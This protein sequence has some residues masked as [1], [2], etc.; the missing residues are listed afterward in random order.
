MV[1]WGP[2]KAKMAVAVE[3][4]PSPGE[5]TANQRPTRGQAAS[6]PDLARDS[7]KLPARWPLHL[8]MAAGYSVGGDPWP[9]ASAALLEGK[10]ETCAEGLI[11]AARPM[12][13]PHC[14]QQARWRPF[15]TADVAC[16]S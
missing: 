3:M 7:R 15:F 6:S 10:G 8:T 14:V 13:R 4:V 9:V 1:V 11:W 12:R 16:C 2:T 5:A